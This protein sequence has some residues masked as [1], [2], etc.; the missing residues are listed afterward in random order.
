MDQPHTTLL[1]YSL[2]SAVTDF[3]NKLVVRGNDGRTDDATVCSRVAVLGFYGEHGE[4]SCSVDKRQPGSDS[5][6]SSSLRYN[7]N[8]MSRGGGG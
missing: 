2:H 3:K 7:G 8:Q 6:S 4:F 5:R 1:Y